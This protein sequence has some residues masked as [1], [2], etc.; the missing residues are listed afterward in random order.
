[1]RITNNINTRFYDS[2]SLDAFGRLRVSNPTTIF[3]SKQI[4]E[5]QSLLWEDLQVSGSGT[6]TSHSSNLASTTIGVTANTTGK[7]IRRTYQRFNYQPGKSQSVLL[8]AQMVSQTSLI[9]IKTAIGIFDDNN[10]CYVATENG[11]LKIVIRSKKSG[12]VVNTKVSQ[13][14]WNLDRLDGTGDSGIRIDITKTQIIVIDFEWL[15]VGRVRFG[16]NIDGIT[17]YCHEVLHANSLSVVYMSTPNLP[18]TYEIENDGTGAATTMQHICSTVI[19]EGGRQSI[20]LVQSISNG[21]TEV[22]ATNAGVYYALLGVRIKSTHIGE[23]IIPENVS[24]AITSAGAF[25]WQLRLNPTVAS[26]FT[27]SDVTNAGFQKATGVSANTVTGGTILAQGYGSSSGTGGS[28]VGATGSSLSNAL[29]LGSNYAGVFDTLVLCVASVGAGDTFLG[30]M[31]L[32]Q[33]S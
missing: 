16:F 15:G 8:T 31:T 6:T 1:M 29:L 10:G 9:G 23:T 28:A 25:E 22:T 26:T 27:Y 5:T 32:R 33:L 3:D 17:Y 7:R 24:V 2:P 13:V 18:L 30:G 12:S 14:D 20:G 19:S 11:V 4:H 21:T